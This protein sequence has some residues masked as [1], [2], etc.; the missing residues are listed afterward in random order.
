VRLVPRLV[1]AQRGDLEARHPGGSLRTQPD[2][3][4]AYRG[5]IPSP[6]KEHR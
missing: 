3:N 4:P 6:A 2:R 1:P 5:S